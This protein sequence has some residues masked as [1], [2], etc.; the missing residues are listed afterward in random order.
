MCTH[1][2]TKNS[3]IC[4]RRASCWHK[5]RFVHRCHCDKSDESRCWTNCTTLTHRRFVKIFEWLT[6]CIIWRL[7]SS[8]SWVRTL[9]FNSTRLDEQD[10]KLSSKVRIR[11]LAQGSNSDGSACSDSTRNL[12]TVAQFVGWTFD[13]G[14]DHT[15]SSN[16][17]FKRTKIVVRF[18]SSNKNPNSFNSFEQDRWIRLNSSNEKSMFNPAQF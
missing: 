15:T 11:E 14:F 7:M 13:S 8:S 18:N 12:K 9:F 3:S 10:S 6:R 1:R 17:T 5:S 4:S 2:R 16:W